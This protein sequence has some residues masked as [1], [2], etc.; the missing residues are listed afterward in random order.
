MFRLYHMVY[1]K[2][3]RVTIEYAS[4]LFKEKGWKLI[5]TVYE[6]AHKRL[7][8]ECDRGHKHSISWAMFQQ[9]RRCAHCSGSI[10]KTI[11]EVREA[12]ESKGWTLL[13]D[14]YL[15]SKQ[16]LQYQCSKGH[17]GETC[18]N[19]FNAGVGCSECSGNKKKNIE[20]IKL[21]F[22]EKGWDLL[23]TEYRGAHIPLRFRCNNGHEHHIRWGH[24]RKGHGC[25]LCVNN[26]L[27]KSLD[28]V[29]KAF[30]KRNFKLL[31]AEYKNRHQKLDFICDRGHNSQIDFGHLIRGGG[32]LQCADYGFSDSKPA[33]LYYIRFEHQGKY[34]YKIGITRN[35]LKRRFAGE[36]KGCKVIQTKSFLF[37]YLARQEEQS[38]LKKYQKYRYTGTPFLTTGF[39]ELFTTDVLKLDNDKS[40]L[41]PV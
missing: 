18:W 19:V 8:F 20:D 7:D 23:S 39:T 40:I 5:S 22:A 4:E 17:K 33:T 26:N 32:C 6:N 41:Q 9:G 14:S 27:P 11:G 34:F 25:A 21:K 15:N 12:F 10:T 36:F 3:K 13:S 2:D 30:E 29:A 28:D 16:I 37:G 24:F 38:I 35:T 31:T 1:K